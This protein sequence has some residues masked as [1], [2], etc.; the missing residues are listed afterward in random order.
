MP[1]L[2]R[3]LFL[4]VGGLVAL[5]LLGFAGYF[6]F[7]KIQQN[8]A[9]TEQLETTTSELQAL[10]DRKP[11]PGQENIDAAKEEEK[12]LQ[13]FADEMQR[14]F[15]P[16]LTTTNEIT[17]RQFRQLLDTVVDELQRGAERAGVELPMTNYWF[18]FAA[19]K[20]MVTFPTNV[21]SPMTSQLLE[22]KTLCEILYDAKVIALQN[23]KRSSV[24]TEDT[25][26]TDYMTNKPATNDFS[27]ATPYEVTFKAFSAELAGVMEGIL[28]S[29]QCIVV[30]NISVDQA[31]AA[32]AADQY[33]GGPNPYG[34]VYGMTPSPYGSGMSEALA[35]R[36]G[37]GAGRPGMDPALAR[38]YGLGVPS[39][40]TPAP[41][42]PSRSGISSLLEEK[43]LRVT[44]SLDVVKLKP[45]PAK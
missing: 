19:Q 12:K 6:L 21:I 43:A 34:P 5:G 25:G 28:R 16:T 13:T 1:W 45:K 38:R 4:V 26:Y 24:A 32:P 40:A 18:T 15:P 35:R 17:E 7:T 31:D 37:M 44:L 41:T 2:K 3:N 10:L 11:F 23:L 33:T 22:V 9:V 27:I 29:P 20:P 8:Q 30:K 42:Q 36:Y 39:P 14:L